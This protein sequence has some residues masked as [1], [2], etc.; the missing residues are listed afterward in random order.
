MIRADV[1][2][3]AGNLVSHGAS[4]IVNH[5]GLVLSEARPLATE[6]VIAEIENRAA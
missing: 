5:D 2:G 4:G 6:L 1:A 3:V